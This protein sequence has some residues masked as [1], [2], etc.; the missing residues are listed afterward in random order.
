VKER[1]VCNIPK[2]RR[3]ERYVVIILG[4][5]AFFCVIYAGHTQVS[6]KRRLYYVLIRESNL[7][8][9]QRLHYW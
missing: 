3:L 8:H 7:G 5:K 2:H 9:S 4:D 1:L 6:L